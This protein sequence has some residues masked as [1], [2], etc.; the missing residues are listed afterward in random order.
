MKPVLEQS[1]STDFLGKDF[2][3]WLWFRSE[4]DN[5]V[6]RLPEIGDVLVWIEDRITLES[7]DDGE[8]VEK[9]QC[10][11]GD[12]P[13]EEARF[14][15]RSSKK[16]TQA[17]IKLTLEDEEWTFVLDAAWLNFKSM[18]GPKVMQDL[19][20]DPEG[21][22]YEKMLLVEKPVAVVDGLYAQFLEVRTSPEWE[23]RELPALLE[24]VHKGE[25]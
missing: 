6:F 15:L 14:A 11:G 24:W 12:A 8:H 5:A 1:R 16:I 25:R 7:E 18:K 9:I 13:L 21:F 20:E 22:F 4:T 2:L 3:I 19:R 23:N 10:S 17:K